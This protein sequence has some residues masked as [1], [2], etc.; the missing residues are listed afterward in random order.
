MTSVPASSSATTTTQVKTGPL[1]DHEVR[2]SAPNLLTVGHAAGHAPDD[3]ASEHSKSSKST[4]LSPGSSR[5]VSPAPWS[6]RT[7]MV[8]AASSQTVADSLI[9]QSYERRLPSLSQSR[10]SGILDT[11]VSQSHERQLP[12]RS[13]SPSPDAGQ[14]APSKLRS[15]GPLAPLSL[16]SLGDDGSS[17]QLIVPGMPI[18]P[19][20]VPSPS[21]RVRTSSLR[22]ESDIKRPFEV[23]APAPPPP[24]GGDSP[25]GSE[26]SKTSSPDLPLDEDSM[27]APQRS[28]RAQSISAVDFPAELTLSPKFKR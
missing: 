18:V 13:P 23:D 21:Q 17:S 4:S 19:Q 16:A 11:E 5:S 24:L 2:G 26:A 6:L 8:P 3:G 15:H 9:V 7:S 1:G 10:P 20:R 14:R 27:G 22:E 28:L 25:Q 12:A